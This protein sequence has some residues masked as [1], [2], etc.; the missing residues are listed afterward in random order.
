MAEMSKFG[1]AGGRD[2]LACEAMLIDALDGALAAE[3]QTAFDAHIATCTTCSAMLADAQRGAAWLS[4]LKS[5]RPEPPTDMV[6]RILAQTSGAQ[7][8]EAAAFGVVQPLVAGTLS[9]PGSVVGMPARGSFRQRNFS[10]VAMKQMM[11]QP[12]LAM[13]AAMA[14]FSI[15]LTLNLTGVKLTEFR[16][17]DLKPSN[18][19]RGF[20]EA[21]ASVIRHY[22]NLRVV[23]EM[24]SRVR[25]LT[26]SSDEAQTAKPVQKDEKNN[27]EQKEQKKPAKP[28]G[29]SH[30]S[31]PI[32]G[33]LQQVS[34]NSS[35]PGCNHAQTRNVLQA[36]DRN[37]SRS[38]KNT[39]GR[40]MMAGSFDGHEYSS[41]ELFN[42]GSMKAMPERGMA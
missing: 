32:G 36:S 24:E 25:D 35:R 6:A 9:S 37:N 33:S 11:M 5:P 42:K 4:M 26:K 14:F 39:G 29:S 12:R 18:L 30:L 22:D 8:A 23:Y 7:A 38:P 21:N 27:D 17:A 41:S 1:A 31:M 3:D 40:V 16:M 13:T 2:C 28:Q 34:A 19:R 10:L 20:Y 15:T